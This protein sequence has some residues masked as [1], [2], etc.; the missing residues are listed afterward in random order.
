[1]PKLPGIGGILKAENE[2]ASQAK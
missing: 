2:D 1:M